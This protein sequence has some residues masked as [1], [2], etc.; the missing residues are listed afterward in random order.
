M[1]QT[2]RR[3]LRRSAS[4]L[5]ALGTLWAV[6][7]AAPLED[8]SGAAAVLRDREAVALALLRYERGCVSDGEPL[9]LAAALAL[10]ELPL[11][12]AEHQEITEAWSDELQQPPAPDAE[13]SEGT[14]LSDGAKEPE[15]PAGEGDPLPPI[16]VRDNGVP[17]V[18]LR[19]SDPAGYLIYENVYVNNASDAPLEA[20]DLGFDF[21]AALTD[22]APQVLIV[23]THGCEAYTM[24]EGEAYEASD[25]HRTLDDTK[26]ILRV[27]D[28][29]ARVL[30]DAG[31][32][33]LHDRTLHDYPSYSGAY[34]RSLATVESYR[35][36]YP[37]LV[38]VLDVHR[39]AVADAAGRQYKL[40]SAEEPEAAQL[41]F[42]IGSDGGGLS[43]DRWRDN[44]KLAAAVQSALLRDYPTL[45]RP[46][47]VRNSRYNQQV[48]PG[49][50]LLEVGTAG[51]SLEEA[52]VAARL[53]A[54]G[55]AETIRNAAH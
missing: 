24:P 11:L 52:L 2:L 45:M 5:L 15:E 4:L 26:N 23:H 6:A 34:N 1:K 27:G 50:L 29:I 42:V 21:S 31:I 54:A 33:V 40:L 37:S 38:Y 18:T 20:S 36:Q 19:P 32:G 53:F 49:A 17:S 48:S 16:T 8:L 44:L 22:E 39:D 7:L 13:D 41:E 12:D 35:A 28:E 51:N 46:I 47:I 3:T 9:P 10:A 14:V 30:T 25:D 55:F 43:H